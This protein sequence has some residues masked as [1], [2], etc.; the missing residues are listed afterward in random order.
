M[1]VRCR[2]PDRRWAAG[3]SAGFVARRPRAA[4][5]AA[6]S[7][8][9]WWRRRGSRSHRTRSA[10]HAGGGRHLRLGQQNRRLP[11]VAFLRSRC[12]NWTACR[13]LGGPQPGADGIDGVRPVGPKPL[14][15]TG[16]ILYAVVYRGLGD[17][18]PGT[19]A[20]PLSRL[21][22]VLRLD[23]AGGTGRV[24]GLAPPARRVRRSAGTTPQW[25][26][27]PSTPR[28]AQVSCSASALRWRQQ[29][30][31]VV[32]SWWCRCLV[33]GSQRDFY[34]GVGVRGRCLV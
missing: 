19:P 1:P 7:G 27:L 30:R 5:P 29:G 34:Q 14:M 11:A 33:T 32:A 31:S 8:V 15:V 23:R 21:R 24:A 13:A 20:G 17:H 12:G 28:S 9:G 16:W 2:T 25:G 22:A 3:G 6:V 4:G 10:S 26:S 18:R